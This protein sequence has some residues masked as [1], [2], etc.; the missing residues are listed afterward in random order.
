MNIAPLSLDHQ[1]IVS[2]RCRELSLPLSEYNFPNL[3]LFRKT[4]DYCFCEISAGLEAIIGTSYHGHRFLMPLQ[5]PKNWGRILSAARESHIDYIYPVSEGWWKEVERSG[6][7]LNSSD[8]SCDYLYD[9]DLIRTYRGR[10]YDGHRNLVRNL[11][12][13]HTVRSE[14]LT[15]SNEQDAVHVITAWAERKNGSRLEVEAC[16][17]AVRMMSVLKLQG[18]IHYVDEVPSGMLIGSHLNHDTYLIHFVKEFPVYRG[19]YQF[20]FQ[21]CAKEISFQFTRLNFEQDLGIASLRQSKLS[22]HPI[23][24]LKKGRLWISSPDTISS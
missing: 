16:Q 4:H 6:L 20:M 2:E 7:S 24:L 8:E 21:Y 5:H 12:S 13:N 18:W 23:A 1:D 9:A 17:E 19:L 14:L 15:Q 11:F 22:Y 3:Y 10:H